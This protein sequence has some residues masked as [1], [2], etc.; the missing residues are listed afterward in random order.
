LFSS[1][2]FVL[3]VVAGLVLVGLAVAGRFGAAPLVPAGVLL[4][5]G[6]LVG[7][8]L[9][10]SA[11]VVS[12]FADGTLVCRRPI[13]ALHTRADRVQRTTRSVLNRSG[14]RTPIVLHTMDGSVLLTHGP[15]TVAEMMA[16]IRGR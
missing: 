4:A 3:L 11:L 6:A 16:T 10:R 13:D 2:V 9:Q 8:Q 14:R 5:V 1:V 7:S 15:D 12:L